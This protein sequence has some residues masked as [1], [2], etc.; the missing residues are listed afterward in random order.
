MNRRFRAV[1]DEQCEICQSFVSWLAVLDRKRII[2]CVPIE[3]DRLSRIHPDLNVQDCLRQLHVVDPDGRIWKGWDAVARLARLFP[4]TW[5]I[6]ALGSVPPFHWLG[7]AAYGFVA[8]NRYALSKCRG[9]ACRVARPVVV[10]RTSPLGAF[11]SC[12]TL[13]MILRLPLVVASATKNLAGNLTRFARTYGRRIS[14]L[15]G[16]LQLLFLRGFPSAVVPLLFGEGFWTVVYDGVA[17]D[18]GSPRMRRALRRHVRRMPAGAIRAVV[19]THQ[20]EEHVGNLNWLAKLAGAPIFLPRETARILQKPPR[21]PFARALIIGQPPPLRMPFEPLC[22]RLRTAGGELEVFAAPGHCDDH[23]VLYDRREKLLVAGD[24]FMGA[25]FSAPNPDVDHCAWIETLERLLQL[26]VEILI[27]GHGLLYTVRNDIPDIPG[28]VVRS[29]PM[30]QMRKKLD[31]LRW[32]R[33]QIEAGRRE[34]LPLRAV[35]ATCFPWN[36][37]NAWE[38][39]L[40]DE[41]MRVMSLGHW[42]RTE[43]VRSF[44]RRSG[45][46]EIFPTV[47]QA[48]FYC[49]G[50]PDAPG[51]RVEEKR[52]SGI[53]TS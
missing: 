9:G 44:V 40:N 22:D 50:A 51:E 42:S 12:Y 38:S 48:R 21:L 24:A 10:R 37:R 27:E 45:G 5:L 43:L 28:V 47:Y 18:P 35:E 30:E 36:R 52:A 41:M 4:A 31:Y 34:G 49:A 15:D 8:A 23:V 26:D 14:L 2:E 39:F 7:R 20:H 1:Y 46:G 19:A 6:G 11:W 3:P 16:K 13:G 32:L 29:S 53:T 17:V 33:E 25:Y